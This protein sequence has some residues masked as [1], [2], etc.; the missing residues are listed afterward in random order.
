MVYF[1]LIL[2]SVSHASKGDNEKAIAKLDLAEEALSKARN[3]FPKCDEDAKNSNHSNP[4]EENTLTYLEITRKRISEAK[5]LVLSC[6][7]SKSFDKPVDCSEV[8]ANGRDKS[9]VYSIWPR[10]RITS[11]K[12]IQVYCDMETDGGG[13]TVIQ[14]RGNFSNQQDFYQNWQNYKNGFGSIERDFW[15]GND[16]IHILS[17]QGQ[18]EARIDLEDAKGGQGYAVYGNFYIDGEN[19]DYALHIDDYTGNLGNSLQHHNG[20]KFS[21]KDRGEFKYA[22]LYKGGWWYYD[23]AHSNLN[24]KYKPGKNSVDSVHWWYFRQNEGLAGA[25][26]KIRPRRG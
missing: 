12:S 16:K 21:T 22:R 9:G 11:G 1:L 2:A 18:Y 15:L 23:W 8:Q 25:E 10:H 3:L 7:K 24:G 19:S 17:N 4:V 26:I 14:R 5:K 20:Q 6:D 13:W